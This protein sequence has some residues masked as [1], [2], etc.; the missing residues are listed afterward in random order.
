MSAY[1]R[2]LERRARRLQEKLQPIEPIGLPPSIIL[3]DENTYAYVHG[4]LRSHL[5]SNV[6]GFNADEDGIEE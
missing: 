5:P 3:V 1:T 4:D 6:Y 2:A